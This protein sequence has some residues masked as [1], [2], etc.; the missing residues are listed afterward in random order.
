[1]QGGFARARTLERNPR[2]R[3]ITDGASGEFARCPQL[4]VA[5]SRRITIIDGHP[6]PDRAR[7]VH[8]LA[9]AYAAAA[10]QAGH[11]VRRINVAEID[12]PILRSQNHWQHEPAPP[13]IAEAGA[14]IEWAD[15]LVL[16]Y[17]L[18]LGDV[19]A[20]FK[21]FLEQVAR[22][23]IAFRY[24]EKGMPEKL[25]AGRSARVI[26]TMGMPGLFYRLFYRAHSLK[27]LERNILKFVGVKPVASTVIGIVEGSPE[28]RA[29]WLEKIRDLGRDGS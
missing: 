9:D 7:F 29:E 14:A 2:F 6:D 22:P 19:P 11:A 13:A 8:A 4:E 12:F 27:S 21:A 23:N 24:R 10:E 26:V 20:L 15:H 5:M 16:L 1:M 25:W 17:P 28:S 18:W 3:N